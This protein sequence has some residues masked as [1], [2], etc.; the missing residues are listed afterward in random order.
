MARGKGDGKQL[1]QQGHFS[2]LLSAYCMRALSLDAR[3]ERM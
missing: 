2:Y 1:S 3:L